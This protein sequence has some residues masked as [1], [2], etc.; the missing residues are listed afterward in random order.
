MTPAGKIR[1]HTDQLIAIPKGVES[2]EGQVNEE[3]SDKVEEQQSQPLMKR[4]YPLCECKALIR[5]IYEKF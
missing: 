4:R 3:H 2:D 5:L 1:N